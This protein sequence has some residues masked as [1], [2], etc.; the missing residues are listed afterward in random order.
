MGTGGTISGAGRYLKERNPQIKI[1][2]ADPY[3]SVFKKFKETGK[4]S[5]EDI[6]P[7][8]IEGIGEDMIPA[9]VD[10]SIIDHFEKVTDKDAALWARRITKEEGIF[11]GYSSGAAFAALYQLRHLLKP[12]DLVVVIF[13]DNGFRNLNKI[14][15]DEWMKEHGFLEPD[16]IKAKDI[17][18]SKPQILIYSDV[19]DTILSAYQKMQENNV[20]QV[21][22]FANGKPAG[23]LFDW[24]LMEKVISNPSIL[25][26]KIKNIDLM[27]VII[28]H[29]ES[30]MP[31]ITDALRKSKGA[32]LVQDISGNYHIIT[33]YDIIEHLKNT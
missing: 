5:Q 13:P 24:M 4:Y 17:I 12:T 18:L 32:V 15:N 27:D 3:G 23:M 28:L 2:G 25:H 8:L 16:K 22:V 26:S 11:V 21:P 19:E 33:A 30:T 14:Y 1:W 31:E 29:E 6:H 10:F 7:Y 9:N 20:S